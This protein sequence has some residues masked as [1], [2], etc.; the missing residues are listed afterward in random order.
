MQLA[1]K[2]ENNNKH[3]LKIFV[4]VSIVFHLAFLISKVPSINFKNALTKKEDE[5]KL[6]ILL[7]SS[8]Q[9]KRQIVQTEQSKDQ[10]KKVKK[11]YLG[12]KDNFVARETKAAKVGSFKQAAKGVRDGQNK[13]VSRSAQK[14]RKNYKDIKFADLAIKPNFKRMDK[15]L[16]KQQAAQARKG[17]QNGSSKQAGL[18]QANDFVKDVALGDFTKLNTQEFAYYGFYHR[19]RQKL[20][21]FWGVNIQDQAEKMLKSGRSIASGQNHLTSLV[22]NINSLGEIIQVK[23]KSTSGV[24]ELDEA[25]VKSFNQAGPFP[26]PPKGM[27]RNGVATIEWGFV[28]NT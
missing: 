1:L 11:A 28:V 9:T 21:Q 26:N 19:I 2:K 25:A 17:L 8:S 20:E 16:K 24:K 5:I 15:V 3:L 22:I 12:K 23:I 4:A 10:L 13:K 27:I 7:N 14:K 18:S 6:K